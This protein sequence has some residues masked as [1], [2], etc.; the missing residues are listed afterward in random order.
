MAIEIGYRMNYRGNAVDVARLERRMHHRKRIHGMRSYHRGHDQRIRGMN[1]GN[2][3][4]NRRLRNHNHVGMVQHLGR[5]SHRPARNQ[6]LWRLR[7]AIEAGS[8]LKQCIGS[9]PEWLS[10]FSRETCLSLQDTICATVALM[11]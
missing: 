10:L 11:H 7:R 5:G 8:D 2:G 4:I 6:G 9:V 3:A 1:C